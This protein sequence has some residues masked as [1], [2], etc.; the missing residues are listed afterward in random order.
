MTGTKNKAV[1]A[2]GRAQLRLNRK[3]LGDQLFSAALIAPTLIVTIMFILVP[4]VDSVI[5]SFMDYKIKNIIS[6]KP[7]VW[8]NFAN[9]LKL[10]TGG[11][12]LPAVLNTFAFVIGVVLAQFI[13]GMALA[14]ILNS[15]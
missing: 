4:V 8:N 6:G 14:L 1:T 15:T 11:K 5:K 10:F 9:Y 3:R 13:L 12:M 7:G 2:G